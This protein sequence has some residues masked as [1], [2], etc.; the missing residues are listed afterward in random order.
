MSESETSDEEDSVN[1]ESKI[2]IDP[3][4]VIERSWRLLCP[5]HLETDVK[6]KWYVVIWLG[7]RT[8]SLFIGKVLHQFLVDKVGI[9][10]QLEMKF[11][12]PKTGSGT[13]LEGTPAHLPDISMVKLSD[14]ILG[15]HQVASEIGA[16][17]NASQYE[18]IKKHFD[19]VKNIGRV[20]LLDKFA[21]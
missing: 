18:V 6:E 2:D 9:V 12:K 11:L 15:S 8:K 1:N 7:K 13:K 20:K 14:I 5:P 17:F 21:I 10:E 16:L 3:C 4:D 19:N